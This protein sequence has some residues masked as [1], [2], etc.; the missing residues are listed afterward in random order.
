MPCVTVEAVIA[1]NKI[2]PHVAV[3]AESAKAFY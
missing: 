3:E 2:V 1:I